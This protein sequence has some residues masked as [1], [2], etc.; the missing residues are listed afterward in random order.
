MS[1]SGFNLPTGDLLKIAINDFLSPEIFI[2]SE[3]VRFVVD[4][5]TAFEVTAKHDCIE[6]RS[7]DA[8]KLDGVIYDTRLVIEPKVSNVVEIRTKAYNE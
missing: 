5:R 8:Y 6:V 7:V 4:G 2:Q 1:Q 3:R